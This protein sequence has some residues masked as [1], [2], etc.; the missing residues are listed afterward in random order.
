MIRWIKK[1]FKKKQQGT[2]PWVIEQ[3][4]YDNIISDELRESI[5]KERRKA[6]YKYI[7]DTVYLNPS[8]ACKILT[9]KI[10]G[11]KIKEC[12]GIKKNECLVVRSKK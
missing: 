2:C 3:F 1:L 12:E 6:Q 7:P 5:V 10:Y 9:S 8:D 11:L 4:K